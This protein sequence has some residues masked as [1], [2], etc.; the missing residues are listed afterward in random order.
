MGSRRVERSGRSSWWR[1]VRFQPGGL[2]LLPFLAVVF[3]SAGP[4]SAFLPTTSDPELRLERTIRTSPFE[5]SSVSMRDA[6]GSAFVPRDNSLWLA[7]DNGRAIYEVNPVTGSLK[8]KIG[9]SSFES[10]IRFGGGATAGADRVRDFESLA[11]DEANDILYVFSGPCCTSSVL[12]T[13]FRLLRGGGGTLQVDSYQPLGSGANY[14]GAG[15]NSADGKIYVGVGA[16][17]RSYDFVTNTAGP[18]FKVPNLSGITGMD[19]ASSDLYVTTN[20]EKLRRID[21]PSKTL[22]AGWTFDLV[23]FQIRD[24]R[25]V[26]LI[27]DRFYVLDGYDGRANGDPLDHAVF[28]FEVLP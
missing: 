13:A 15:W 20:A 16:K 3:V 27:D 18:I 1:R 14:T 12:P 10:A 17:L 21:W 22:V 5:G 19:F 7:D 28:V 6:E 4:A 23:P 24:S 11:Y 26:D 2:L 25:A 8:R 9:A